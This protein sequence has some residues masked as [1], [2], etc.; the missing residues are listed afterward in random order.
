MSGFFPLFPPNRYDHFDSSGGSNSKKC[1]LFRDEDYLPPTKEEDIAGVETLEEIEMVMR[2]KCPR[3]G[4]V[5]N[6]VQT[7]TGRGHFVVT[8]ET[9]CN[10]DVNVHS[11]LYRCLVRGK[12]QYLIKSSFTLYSTYVATF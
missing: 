4:R 8:F 7:A 3:C 10:R 1:V 5:C 11:G 9:Q 6:P 2:T 12:P